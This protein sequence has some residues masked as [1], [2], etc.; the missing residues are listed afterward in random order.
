MED[1]LAEDSL[2]SSVVDKTTMWCLEVL[3]ALNEIEMEKYKKQKIQ[4]IAAV[5]MLEQSYA[6]GNRVIKRS[7]TLKLFGK[8]RDKV[9]Y[10]AVNRW[11]WA[12]T[13]CATREALATSII[14]DV[15]YTLPK[16]TGRFANLKT[17][18]DRWVTRSVVNKLVKTWWPEDGELYV[19]S[20]GFDN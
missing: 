1:F 20:K 4:K 12:Y 14:L 16:R 11:P 8:I 2:S 17:K 13:P 19:V 15:Y 6:E 7:L 9:V 5:S 18:I 3:T 10:I